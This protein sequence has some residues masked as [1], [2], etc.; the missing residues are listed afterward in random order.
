MKAALL[1]C[2]AVL[3][4]PAQPSKG[5]D[6]KPFTTDDRIKTFQ[7]W[8]AADPSSTSNKTLLAAA[9]IQKTRETADS[10]YLDRAA[11][12]IEGVLAKTR[13]REALRLRNLIELNRHNFAK[14][15]EYATEMT[16]SAPGDPQTWGSLG[17]ALMEMGRYEEAQTAFAK[18]LSLKR[19]LFSLNRMAHYRF[20][21]GDAGGAI[22]MMSEAARE[23][24]RFPENRA[25]CLTELGT[26][27]FKTGKTA[28]AETAFV[29]AI[30]EFSQ[31]HGAYAGL[32]AIRAAEGRIDEAIVNYRKAQSI[33]P[34]IQYA[35][36]LHDL[37]VRIG[38]RQEA[39]KQNGLIDVV[40]RLE[41]A[42]NQKANRTLATI[43]ANQ[44]RNLKEAL[45]AVEADIVVRKD[46]YTYDALAWVLHGLG[47]NEE[48]QKASRKALEHNTP[49]P[50][51]FY[52]A[53][54]IAHA[55]GERDAARRH[56]ERSLEL[57]PAFD[58]L[59]AATARK[60]LDS[61]R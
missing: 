12:I 23:A 53:G 25:W 43:Y 22:E 27:L 39:A 11:K 60:V 41:A 9:Y 54:M 31:A 37:Y 47:R 18:M 15:V 28:E 2:I 46:V 35:A 5:F 45:E 29:A 51:F 50:V 61:L 13:D 44:Q 6:G 4:A 58:L 16:Q 30:G 10:S 57:N 42:G 36:G 52:H 7:E 55:L 49:E 38:N 40:A 33:T 3:C 21:M 19:T 56:L 14:V 1:C 20:V 24:V 59:Q 26:M 34:L 48:A 17:D 32:G 8:V